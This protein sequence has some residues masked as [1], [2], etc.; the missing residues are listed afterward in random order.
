V[1]NS[2]VA[3][4]V[5]AAVLVI[6]AATGCAGG[7]SATERARHLPATSE[8]PEF[9]VLPDPAFGAKNVAP[10]RPASISV[11]AGTLR[12]VE[13]IDDA[14]TAVEGKLSGDKTV[15]ESTAKLDFATKYKWRGEAVDT[16]GKRYPI[17]GSFRTVEPEQE[18]TA[19]TN[20]VE[21]GVYPQDLRIALTFSTP[22]EKRELVERELRIETSPRMSGSWE[23]SEDGTVVTW[24]PRGRWKPGTKVELTA[25]LYGVMIAPGHYGAD[26]KYLGFRI[27]GG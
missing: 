25:Q 11:T 14:G 22:V 21:G 1:R 13:L 17:S 23:W 27:T 9:R 2:S 24:E 16:S 15:W 4:T 7:S 20:V 26:D 3:V 8:R 12:S 19:T 5:L 10:R 18:V 6:G